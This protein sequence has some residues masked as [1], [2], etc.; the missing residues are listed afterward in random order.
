MKN[1]KRIAALVTLLRESSWGSDAIEI[2]GTRIA[3]VRP[4]P[5]VAQLSIS[6]GQGSWGLASDEECREALR[7]V[8]AEPVKKEERR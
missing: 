5:L 6:D 7:R 1:E 4:A 8:L 2:I 3:R